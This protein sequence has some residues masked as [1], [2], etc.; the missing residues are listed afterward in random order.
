MVQTAITHPKE[1]FGN[2]IS[3]W[4]PRVILLERQRTHSI[5]CIGDRQH[6]P[7]INTRLVIQ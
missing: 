5:P 3:M 6:P 4:E 2:D 1:K 7:D